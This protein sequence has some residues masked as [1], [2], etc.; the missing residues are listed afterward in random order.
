MNINPL[1]KKVHENTSY[2]KLTQNKSYMG[3]IP[4]RIALANKAKN[5]DAAAAKIK[6]TA[7]LGVKINKSNTVTT[8][9]D[10][11][12]QSWV[13]AEDAVSPTSVAITSVY[14]AQVWAEKYIIGTDDYKQKRREFEEARASAYNR[15][16]INP[17]SKQ[18]PDLTAGQRDLY[19]SLVGPFGF[20]YYEYHLAYKQVG[21]KNF[22]RT[23]TYRSL[24]PLN[25]TTIVKELEDGMEAKKKLITVTSK[26]LSTTD[27]Q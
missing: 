16:G 8:S 22:T 18:R 24:K 1:N 27:N 10:N 5:L 20:S 14:M 2:L 13:I 23:K 11:P 15:I 6:A 12:N 7:D 17:A 25:V 19:N 21:L 26:V 3:P 4:E 9:S